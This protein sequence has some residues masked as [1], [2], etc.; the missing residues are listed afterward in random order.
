MRVTNSMISNRAQVHIANA[1]NKLL[2]A[3][4]QYTTGK[5]IQRPSDDPTV[6]S[7]SL[8]FRTTYS[9]LTQYVEKNVKDAM[10]W[11][12]KTESAMKAAAGLLTDMKESFSYGTN[13]Y[14]ES[15]ERSALL[16]KLRQFS[17]AIFEDNADSDF[18]G[19]RL[20]TGYRTDTSLLFPTASDTLEYQIKE[21]FSSSNIDTIRNVESN[22]GYVEGNTAQE[23]AEEQEAKVNTC[24][25]MQLSYD[26]CSNSAIKNGDGTVFNLKV[27]TENGTL[28]YSPDDDTV[29]VVSM[30]DPYAYD[31]DK[32]NEEN[33]TDYKVL[34]VYDA[35]EVILSDE[36]YSDIQQ[37]NAD[38][39]IEYTKKSF[40]KGD[41]RPEMYFECTRYDNISK[42]K[43]EFADPSGQKINYEINFS[44]TITTNTQ[45]KDAFSTQIYRSL[46]YIARA[47]DAVT[48]VENRM[49]DVEKKI[50]NTTDEDEIA[51]LNILLDSLKKEQ[52]LRVSVMNEAF[53]KGLTM[54]ENTQETLNVAVADLGAKYNRLQMTYDRLLDERTSTEEKLSD[55]EEMDISDL[56]IYLTQADNL[57]N[58]A[59][60]ATARILGNSLL[61]YI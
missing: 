39:T 1:K 61:N 59:L 48:D 38:I 45:A 16:A 60:S 19:R 10:E 6:A 11:M 32:Y 13:S 40:E 24:Y 17:N 30:N 4:E 49:A 54:V 46:D 28:T 9:I 22:I 7:R 12:D 50:S 14:P 57:Y 5:K 55:N 27:I 25:R 18:I 29:G 43:I 36:V 51:A 53:G 44:Q 47:I 20:F 21:K 31:I 33:G 35:G 52:E 41:I 23:Y 15:E 37:Y 34:Y 26:N 42:K 3:E 8:K 58:A 2:T 56:I